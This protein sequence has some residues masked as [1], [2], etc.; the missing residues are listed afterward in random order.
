MRWYQTWFWRTLESLDWRSGL[1]FQGF[2]VDVCTLM[3][4]NYVHRLLNDALKWTWVSFLYNTYL[5]RQAQSHSTVDCW[6]P[7]IQWWQ[8]P[9]PEYS[10]GHR[11][12]P[13]QLPLPMCCRYWSGYRTSQRARS[14]GLLQ[15]LWERR[16][17]VMI[18]R[19]FQWW[20]GQT[21]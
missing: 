20:N 8:I 11:Q 15:R 4:I 5:C 7:C 18:E 13:P 12:T 1:S 3:M 14:S 16:C 2:V 6:G 10:Q 9:V 17:K 21:F 19:H